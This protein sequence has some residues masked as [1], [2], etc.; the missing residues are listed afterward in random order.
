[1]FT[2]G[3]VALSSGFSDF[4]LLKISSIKQTCRKLS[5]LV[6]ALEQQRAASCPSQA[7]FQTAISALGFS[8][9]GQ[10]A[11]AL[12]CFFLLWPWGEA[13]RTQKECST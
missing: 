13:G 7:E 12:T 10:D 9:V 4:S 3:E 11:S 8:F 5:I 6:G 2:I 1:M